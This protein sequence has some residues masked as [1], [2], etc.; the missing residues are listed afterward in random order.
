M[1]HLFFL[2]PYNVCYLISI[3]LAESKGVRFVMDSGVS[4]FKGEDGKLK[5]VILK[6]GQTIA[7]EV[8]VLGVGV[9]PA[10]DFL[11][12]SGLKMTDHGAVCV[13]KVS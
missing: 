11:S 2:K 5:K 6:N 7:A 9:T 13:D 12:D 10:T 1:Q 8:C 4:E 3:Q